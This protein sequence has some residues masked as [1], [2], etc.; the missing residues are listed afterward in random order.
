MEIDYT[1]IRLI[2]DAS[3]LVKM[4]MI[5]L[6]LISVF[7][8]TLIAVKMSAMKSAMKQLHAFEERFWS[9]ISL[10]QLYE[11]LANKKNTGLERIFHDG[12]REYSRGRSSDVL[13][14][15][16]AVDA[17]QRAMHVAD[18][19]EVEKLEHNLSFFATVGSV[20]PYIGLFGTVWGIMNSF[21]AI[22]Q[23]NQASL[24]AVAP[25]IAEALIATAFG[26]LAAIPA[27]IA[28]NRFT[29]QLDKIALAYENFRT[30]FL[31]LLERHRLS[32]SVVQSSM[33]QP[34]DTLSASSEESIVPVPTNHE[35]KT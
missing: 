3:L 5:L 33:S 6:V 22:G 9:D 14:S 18:A 15:V 29:A 19:R 2:M 13:R 32:Q 28:Y 11:E 4:V 35:G 24:E 23:Q 20:S 34:I 16:A 8:W 17:A 12:Y 21:I 1:V 27:Y 26:L 10:R 7:S 25:G 31:T 30:E